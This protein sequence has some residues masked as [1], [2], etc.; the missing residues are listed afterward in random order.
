[1]YTPTETS[2]RDASPAKASATGWIQPSNSNVR[3]I[4]VSRDSLNELGWSWVST[5]F[6]D[7]LAVGTEQ[8]LAGL[9]FAAERG[10]GATFLD[11]ASRWPKAALT[12][13]P[14]RSAHWLHLAAA[15]KHRIDLLL[16]G[17][18]FQLSVWRALLT[19]PAGSKATY[20]EIA[21]KA[22]RPQAVR[23]VGTAIGS[24]PVS[25]FIPCHRAVRKDGG[26]GGYRWGLSV[27]HDLLAFEASSPA[28]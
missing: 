12:E 13:D 27:K 9:G 6:G 22:Q 23:A 26:A 21:Q 8:G 3:L 2:N 11:M 28:S 25:W 16:H 14:E 20:S 24:N 15:G 17:T 19:I 5:P 10:R 18:P 4:P 7:A 1:M